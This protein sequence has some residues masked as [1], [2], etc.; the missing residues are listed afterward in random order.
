MGVV[1]L[2]CRVLGGYSRPERRQPDL[3]S[4]GLMTRVF[5]AE[6]RVLYRPPMNPSSRTADRPR[7]NVCRSDQFGLVR[8]SGIAF[9]GN[10]LSATSFSSTFKLRS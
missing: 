8:I 5:P 10:T 6:V 4:V 2:G 9:A 3:E 7:L 1:C